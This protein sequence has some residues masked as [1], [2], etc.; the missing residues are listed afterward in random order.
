MSGT[1][2]ATVP[3]PAY[4]TSGDLPWGTSNP[5]ATAPPASPLAQPT[6]Q[7]EFATLKQ[8]DAAELLYA[9]FQLTPDQ[10]LANGTAVLQQA[11]TLLAALKPSAAA[12]PATPATDAS[13][14]PSYTDLISK[15]DAAANAALAA[16]AKAPAGS[17]ILDVQA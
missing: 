15:S 5:I 12:P 2:G 14:L 4:Y 6:V 11:S 7:K 10:A 17:S 1:V 13:N 9:S 8:Y 16:L 3:S